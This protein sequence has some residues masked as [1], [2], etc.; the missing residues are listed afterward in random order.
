MGLHFFKL[1]LL[2]SSVIQISDHTLSIPE[3]KHLFCFSKQFLLLNVSEIS[4]GKPQLTH[5]TR[6]FYYDNMF[7]Q[8]ILMVTS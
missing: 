6:T 8:K 4:K 2:L 1:L 5:F 3:E 7:S